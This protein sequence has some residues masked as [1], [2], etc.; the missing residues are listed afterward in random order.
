M[1]KVIRD[2]FNSDGR[3]MCCKSHACNDKI[4]NYMVK[5]QRSN[6]MENIK[7]N[8]S[9]PPKSNSLKSSSTSH[10]SDSQFLV[11]TGLVFITIL[12]LTAGRW[13]WV[14]TDLPCRAACWLGWLAQFSSL[15][16][17]L[18][19]KIL[20]F[21]SKQNVQIK[22]LGSWN[23]KKAWCSWSMELSKLFW[24]VLMSLVASGSGYK[25]EKFI[26][27]EAKERGT[28]C[29]DKC[30]STTGYAAGFCTAIASFT[31]TSACVLFQI[32]QPLICGLIEGPFGGLTA[33]CSWGFLDSV[34][35]TCEE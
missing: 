9:P 32:E 35:E 12:K 1:D 10:N 5:Y 26:D 11:K 2:N 7:I 8:N 4:P 23:W 33:F 19:K 21:L 6:F 13:P 3:V 29:R 34:C 24:I 30:S 31:A 27:W 16:S 14:T 20:D 18:S 22:S 15:K 28:E 25:A 17:Q